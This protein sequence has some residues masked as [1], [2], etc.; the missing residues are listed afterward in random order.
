MSIHLG[1]ENAD[2]TSSLDL[3]LSLLGEELSLDNDRDLGKSTLAEN[4][5]VTSAGNIDDGSLAVLA[6]SVGLTSLL[7]DKRP[8]LVDVDNGNVV[9]ILLVVEV[10][11]TDLTEV[12][13]VTK[14]NAHNELSANAHRITKARRND[15]YYLSIR[16]LW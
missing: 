8:E 1:G 9:L 15:A 13:R 14:R 5:E 11:H 2:T 7:R 12:T 6:G 4:L 10:T 3:L 16:I